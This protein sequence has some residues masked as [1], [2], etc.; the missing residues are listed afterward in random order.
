MNLAGGTLE[1]DGSGYAGEAASLTL[2]NSANLVG[3]VPETKILITGFN[4]SGLSARIVQNGPDGP[5]D[6]VLVIE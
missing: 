4:A 6:V 2:L 5:G 3:V 1:I